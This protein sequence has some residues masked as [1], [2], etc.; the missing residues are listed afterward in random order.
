VKKLFRDSWG[1]REAAYQIGVARK[2]GLKFRTGRELEVGKIEGGSNEAGDKGKFSK[3]TGR[4]Q[5]AGRDNVERCPVPSG[6]GKGEQA[7]FTFQENEFEWFPCQMHPELLAP[8]PVE[9]GEIIPGEEEI[10]GGE[11]RPFAGI[12][13]EK[14]EGMRRAVHLPVPPPLRVGLELVAAN[15]IAGRNGDAHV[16]SGVIG[17]PQYLQ[18]DSRHLI[19]SLHLEQRR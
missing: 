16:P 1:T 13:G 15:E 5:D 2:E 4:L 12:A 11:G 3:G 14:P 10:D 7:G 19:Y 9:G 17:V 18:A 8:H 6:R